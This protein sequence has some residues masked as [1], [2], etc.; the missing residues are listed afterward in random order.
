MKKFFDTQKLASQI[1]TRIVVNYFKAWAR[2]MAPR[3]K[4]NP[5]PRLLYI[6]LFSGPGTFADGSQSTPLLVLE[7]AIDNADLRKMLIALFNDADA[8]HAELLK[9]NIENLP[10]YDTL[11]TPPIIRT[12][13][14]DQSIVDFFSKIN[15][16][17]AFSFIDPF[18]YKGL[19][20]ELIDALVR[21]WGCDMVLFFSFN[22]INRALTNPTVEKHI[23]ALFG[24][25]KTQELRATAKTM[26]AEQREEL[27]IEKFME[28][29]RELGYSYIVPYFFKYAEKD[30]T[31]HYL[32]FI[33]K[34]SLGFKIMKEIMFKESE[35]KNQNVANF[36][37]V[38]SLSKN[39]TPLLALLNTPLDD[40][41]D[42][43]CSEFSGQTLTR[44]DLQKK[45]D[46]EHPE[47][48][49]VNRN[50]TDALLQLE[51]TTKII[52]SP[53]REKRK[54]IKGTPTFGE[55]TSVTFPKE[56]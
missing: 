10:G 39:K 3:V 18:G 47:N 12:G 37:H 16:Q 22:S 6:D 50:W 13:E 17:P 8:N 46:L 28:A 26:N 7:H 21:G 11:K 20:L 55:N 40:F 44:K 5:N 15:M 32:I 52:A 14:I 43:L 29:I 51:S 30:R 35:D 27:L 33:S 24:E 36:G 38:G 48:P 25:Q 19:T 53:P 9:K 34:H 2:I 23:N 45:Y 31:S 56:N 1:K 41:C 42:E 4:S 54:S 49:F